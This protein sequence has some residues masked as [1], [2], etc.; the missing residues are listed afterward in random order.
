[1]SQGSRKP[2]RNVLPDLI[3]PAL[4]FSFSI[5]YLSTI[6]DVPWTS[7]AS[8]VFVS[9]LLFIAIAVYVVRTVLRIRRGEETIRLAGPD[10]GISTEA[11]RVALLAL[12]IA[13]VFLLG[14]LGFTLAT[15]LFLVLAIIILSSP[16][17][18]RM[19]LKVALSCSI[20]GYVIF[21]YFFRTRFPEGLIETAVE[22]LLR[23]GS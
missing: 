15:A 18:W 22:E 5:Y 14:W 7:Q 20:A 19:A 13:Y 10:V 1:M 8:A 6:T 21:I 2:A 11:K 23:N 3:I 17:N 12:T 9:S 16:G 4:A